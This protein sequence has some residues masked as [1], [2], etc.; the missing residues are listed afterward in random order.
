MSEQRRLFFALSPTDECRRSLVDM[1]RRIPLAGGR[2]VPAQNLHL[3]LAFL[4]SVS[5]TVLEQL[6]V[7]TGA[8]RGS[9]IKMEIVRC[10]LWRRQRILWV[11][12]EKSPK[13]L[14]DLVDQLRKVQQKVGLIPEDRVYEPHITLARRAQ[15]K[16]APPEF[17]P[18]KWRSD[19]FSLMESVM[20]GEG[21]QYRVVQQWPLKA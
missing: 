5:D 8:V 12:P 17:G 11:G 16:T 14:T 20:A 13:A 15:L 3:T 4:G 2:Q 7:L 18:I 6:R 10:E 1:Q 19:H 21:V 9:P